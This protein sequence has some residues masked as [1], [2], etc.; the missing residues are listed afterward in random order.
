MSLITV[1]FSYTAYTHVGLITRHRTKRF[2]KSIF[3]LP[4]SSEKLF[5]MSASWPFGSSVRLRSM[6]DWVWFSVF[7]S[8]K[9]VLTN[10]RFRSW[11][12]KPSR[13]RP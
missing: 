2:R 3:V 9:S 6:A 13:G 8:K 11:S 1:D 5:M 7:K 12:S 4:R 10:V